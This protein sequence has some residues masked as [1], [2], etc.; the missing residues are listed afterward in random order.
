M[1][2]SK[3]KEYYYLVSLALRTYLENRFSLKAPEQTTEEFLESVVNS[4]K[5]E[6]RHINILKEYLNHCDLVKYAKFDPGNAQAKALV[7][8][9]RQ[10][11]D[12]T[13]KSKEEDNNVV[14]DK[15]QK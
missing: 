15:A 5:L 11:I 14:M 1:E 6:G 7:D 10:F 3:I 12:E 8:T 13:A 4:D 2:K 9:T